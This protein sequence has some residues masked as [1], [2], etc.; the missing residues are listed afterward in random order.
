[1]T[2]SNLQA[3][4]VR[5]I[6][7]MT[8]QQHEQLSLPGVEEHLKKH[9]LQE[10]QMTRAQWEAD[11]QTL[12][13]AEGAETVTTG[14]SREG[15]EMH[16]D[17]GGIHFGDYQSAKAAGQFKAEQVAESF[18]GNP[19]PVRMFSV[20]A[21]GRFSNSPT[22]GH[23]AFDDLPKTTGR[24]VVPDRFYGGSVWPQKKTGQWYSNAVE[25][26]PHWKTKQ[27]DTELQQVHTEEGVP[28]TQYSLEMPVDPKHYG[29]SGQYPAKI[30]GNRPDA[31]YTAPL[32]GY[33]PRREGFLRT[34]KEVVLKAHE[35][36][37][38]VPPAILSEAQHSPEWSE[39]L[40][41]PETRRS[42]E[43]ASTQRY[44]KDN[45]LFKEVRMGSTQYFVT[46]DPKDAL[47]NM[48]GKFGPPQKL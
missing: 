40:Q 25:G 23:K 10:W 41:R 36:G 22:E 9:P 37:K 5:A 17:S 1:M 19:R 13:R 20:R 14:Y 44:N 46:E 38:P 33:V 27:G 15:Q 7:E 32:S 35:E 48:K 11:P 34:H 21:S 28:T 39:T 8:G 31:N 43:Q 42:K 6:R 18:W 16:P 4:R 3:Q 12:W 30:G 47:K 26:W 24:D 29:P 2:E 45:T